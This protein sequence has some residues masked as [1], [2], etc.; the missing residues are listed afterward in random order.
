MAVRTVLRMGDPV[1]LQQAVKIEAFDTPQ[2][3]AL[4]QDMQDTMGAMDGAGIAAPQIGESVQVVIFGVGKNPRYPDAEEVPYTVLIN[5]VL[6]EFSEDMEDGWEGCLSVPGMRGIVPRHIKLRYQGFDQYG[7]AIDRTVSGFHARV[8]QH[9]CDHLWGI[10][11]PMRIRD[12]RNF[13]FADVLFPGQQLPD[14]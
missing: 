13:G 6:T 1:L 4:I 12:F 9:E 11:Y 2:L 7:N 3:H 5:P 14:E 10:L 8:V